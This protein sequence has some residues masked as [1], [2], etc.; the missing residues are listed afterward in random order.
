MSSRGG[1]PKA[2]GRSNL[3]DYRR[4]PK[5]EYDG[6]TFGSQL[7]ANLYIYL[8]GLIANG[9]LIGEIR[10][11]V[12]VYMTRAR[13]HC[14]PDFLV[15]DPQW[16]DVYYEAKGFENDRWPVTKLL[17]RVYGPGRLRIFKGYGKALRMVEEIIPK[18]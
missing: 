6:R 9:E 1:W 13:Y 3:V 17:W 10:C 5:V 18:G 11:Q 15:T 12:H 4:V 8:K 7:E 16:G 2:N 14:I